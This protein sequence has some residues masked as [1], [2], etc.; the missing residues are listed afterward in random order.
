MS[1]FRKI[2]F[3]F[4]LILS[5]FIFTNKILAQEATPTPTPGTSTQQVQ[6]LQNQINDLQNKINDLDNQKKTLSSQIAVMDNQV[7]LTQL[8]INA[9]EKQITDLGLD[10]DTADKKINNLQNSLQKLTGVLIDRIVATYEVG[11]VQ[12]FHVLLSSSNASNFFTK[13][14]YLKIAQEHDKKLIYDTT[15]AKADYSNQKEIF[16]EKKRKVENLQSQ[17]ESYNDQLEQE[18]KAKQTLLSETQG[19]EANYQ[20][21]LSAAQAQLAGFSRFVTSQGGASIL[22]GQTVCDDWGC[23]YNQRDSQWGN[24]PLNGTKYT[25]A[26]DGCLVTAMAMVYTHLGRRNVTPLT[27]NSNSSNFASYYPAYLNKTISADGMTTSRI[28]ASIDSELSAGRPVI[29]GIG[30]GPDHFVVF[31]SGSGGNYKMNDPFV[32]NGHNINFTDHYSISNIRSI[33]RVSS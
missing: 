23:Y 29:I 3:I 30:A 10:I 13:L 11:T 9:T 26:S 33:E 20:R 22:S 32:P 7:K 25:L 15:Q 5:I 6:D 17:L 4:L 27:I 2:Q 12:P 14:N 18:K 16:Q 24:V 31:I 1:I 19:S 28:F 8:K 21:L